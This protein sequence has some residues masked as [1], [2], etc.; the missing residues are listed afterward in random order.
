VVV[1]MSADGEI[2]IILNKT[3]Q[4]TNMK[5]IIFE[6]PGKPTEVLALQEVEVPQPQA[7][8]VRVRVKASP[9]NPSDVAF[10]QG[11]YGI[12]PQLP[13]GAGFEGS[14]VVEAVGEGVGLP[15]GTRV[16]FTGIGAW[17]EQ[18]VVSARAVMPLPDALPFEV[19]AQV[20][21]N[22]LT[23]WA[24]LHESGLQA[25]DWLLLTAGGSTFAQ[26]V[27][28]YAHRRGIR[29]ICTVR[30]DDQVAQL[31]ALGATEVINT[32]LHPLPKRVRELTDK[33]GV[34]CCFDAV[35]G[36]LGALALQ[37]LAN[38]GQ[39]LVYG[40]LSLQEMPLNS[41][42]LIFRSATVRGFWLTDW[43]AT[44]DKPLRAQASQDTLTMLAS[45]ELK[46]TIDAT[47][48]LA[49]TVEAVAHAEAPGRTGKVLIVME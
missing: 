40:M 2:D 3:N 27:V 44:A 19:G 31:K 35:G 46:V 30:R 5:K 12:R 42:L 17:A 48:P 18:V 28:Q 37:C 45:G 25:G 29:T 7:G 11:G 34:P 38:K 36:E 20:F 32:E 8:E 24:M 4:N 39:M 43:L 10:V 49:K 14:G 1:V 41:G 23:A 26:L 13:S 21:V 16:S 47:Y 6:K 15:V 33:K 9:V 22:P